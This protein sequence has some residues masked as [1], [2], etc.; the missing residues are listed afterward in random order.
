MDEL[1]IYLPILANYR[2][3]CAHEDIV[4]ENRTQKEIGDTIFH[5]V[6]Q[7][8]KEN[9]EF[10]YGKNDAFALMIIMKQLLDKEKFKSMSIEVDN[11]IR[12]LDYNLKTISTKDVL[13][14]MG[15]P[16]NWKD[17]ANIERSVVNEY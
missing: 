4:Y 14:H 12:T 7:I 2:N 9:G 3:L 16:R 6:L 13:R 1:I 17:L 10:I 8:P 5:K 15:F 11:A